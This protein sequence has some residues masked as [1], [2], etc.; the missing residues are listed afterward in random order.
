MT[1][2]ALREGDLRAGTRS[3]RAKLKFD[4]Q[5]IAIARTQSQTTIYSDDEDISTLAEPLG[6]EV[7]PVHALPVPPEGAQGNLE[8]GPDDES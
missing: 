2:E 8:L 1:R 7:V 5:I 6:L 3:T 4:R